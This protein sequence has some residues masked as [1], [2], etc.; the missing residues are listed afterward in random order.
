MKRQCGD[1]QLCCR[2]LAVKALGKP[3]HTRCKHQKFHKGCGVYNTAAMPPEC[4]LWSCRWVLGD[5]T[6]D[7]P[8]PDRSHY[9]IDVMPDF[10]TLQDNQT[11]QQQAIPVVQI[12][13]DPAHPLAHR[14]PALRAYLLR[15]GQE[16]IAALVRFENKRTAMLFPPNMIGEGTP[17][18]GWL[19]DDGWIEVPSDSPNAKAEPEHSFA[20]KVNALGGLKVVIEP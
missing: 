9:V 4:R 14:D 15:R 18:A 6:G 10:I 2:L 19:H 13:V 5:D 20:D 11:G 3:H 16:G 12:W 8:R 17:P 7:L 1:C